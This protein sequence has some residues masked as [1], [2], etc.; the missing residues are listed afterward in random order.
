MVTSLRQSP[1]SAP[2]RGAGGRGFTLVE[3]LVVISIIAV[4]VGITMPAIGGARQSA[5]RLKCL[6]NLHG[7]GHAFELYYKDNREILPYVLPFYDIGMPSNPSD[8]QLLEVLGAYMD[9]EPP[10]RD[11]SGVLRV[12]PPYLCPSDDDPEGGRATGLSYQY[13]AGGLMFMREVFRAERQ[14][15][16][17]VTRFYEQNPDFPVMA[18]AKPWHPGNNLALLPGETRYN[19]NALYFGDWHANWLRMKPSRRQDRP[20]TPEGPPESRG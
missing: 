10:S 12:Y 6:T 1:A 17:T 9:V 13:W 4:L 3:L 16:R 8:P 5:R 14:P 19:Q 18:D 11:A 2:A 7:W 15:Q 20:E